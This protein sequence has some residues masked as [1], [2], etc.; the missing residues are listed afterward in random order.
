MLD[1]LLSAGLI[2]IKTQR[3]RQEKLKISKQEL[4]SQIITKI[5][6]AANNGKTLA[7]ITYIPYYNETEIDDII[8]KLKE[9][10]YKVLKPKNV[11]NGF[12]IDWS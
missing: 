8:L 7:E 10:G 5:E 6:K 1:N 12:I 2:R 11:I 3:G 4:C 9:K